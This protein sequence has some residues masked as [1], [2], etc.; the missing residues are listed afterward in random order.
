MGGMSTKTSQHEGQA[1][2]C[3][4]VC[5]TLLEVLTV[6]NGVL[7]LSILWMSWA[8][9]LLIV[10]RW[11][12]IEKLHGECLPCSTNQHNRD[13]GAFSSPLNGRFITQICCHV[14]PQHKEGYVA[15]VSDRLGKSQRQ[16]KRLWPRGKAS[17]LMTATRSRD[18][19]VRFILHHAGTR[20]LVC[21]WRC[22]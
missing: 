6:A 16:W 12:L 17:I 9:H 8:S 20:T 22:H 14:I 15:D 11:L 13:I 18:E 1:G 21:R 19:V 5:S 7:G 4:K 2:W 10:R 3:C